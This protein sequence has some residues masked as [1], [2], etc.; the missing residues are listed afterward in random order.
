MTWLPQFV[1][2][3]AVGALGTLLHY[4]VLFVLVSLVGLNAVVA[5][6]VG[7]IAGAV[8][9]YL[10]NHSVTFKSSERHRR[11][12]VKFALVASVGFAM[13]AALMFVTVELMRINYLVSQ[14][15]ATCGVLVWNFAANRAWTFRSSRNA[16]DT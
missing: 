3:A 4:L 11:A 9:N 8:V 10:L 5:S 6:S 13:N 15:F 14:V 12:A 2:F 16:S 1:S 7:A